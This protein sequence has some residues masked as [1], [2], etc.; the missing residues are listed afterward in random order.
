LRMQGVTRTELPCFPVQAGFTVEEAGTRQEYL[1]VR[2]RGSASGLLAEPFADQGSSL[3]S[4]LS[5]ADGLAL[6]PAGSRVEH[7]QLIDY[8]PFGGLV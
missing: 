7:G 4:S 2:L 3:L 6:V 1:R 5:W 8:L